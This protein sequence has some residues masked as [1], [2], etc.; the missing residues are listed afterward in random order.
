MVGQALPIT[1]QVLISED[2]PAVATQA[3]GHFKFSGM[4]EG[5]YN[6]CRRSRGISKVATFLQVIGSALC[7][8]A[9]HASE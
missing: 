2:R 7:T 4:K 9:E 5:D 1:H 8:E 6:Q 3:L